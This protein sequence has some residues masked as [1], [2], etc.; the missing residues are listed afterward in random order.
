[1]VSAA[2]RPDARTGGPR[3]WA[4]GQ[5]AIAVATAAAVVAAV[6]EVTSETLPQGPTALLVVAFTVA[7]V[8]P[9]AIAREHPL[10]AAATTLAASALLVAYQQPLPW[11]VAVAAGVTAFVLARTRPWRATVAVPVAYALLALLA[12]DASHTLAALGAALARPA[13]AGFGA[14]LRWRERAAWLTATAL[15]AERTLLEHVTLEERAGIA[16]ELHDVVA[17]HI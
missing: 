16:R 2:R 17:H 7:A 6:A 3:A 1:M 12:P 5:T 14:A 13:G 10:A 11:V 4:G 8:A 15:D 9:C